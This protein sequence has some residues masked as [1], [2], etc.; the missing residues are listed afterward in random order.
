MNKTIKKT[1]VLIVSLLSLSV[2]LFACSTSTSN[3]NNP[4]GS[5][6]DSSDEGSNT[7]EGLPV[8]ISSNGNSY[9]INDLTVTENGSGNTVVTCSASG[10]DVVPVVGG[11]TVIPIYCSIIENGV[12]TEFVSIQPGIDSVD[13]IFNTKLDPDTV[14][15]YPQDNRGKR[16]EITIK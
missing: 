12:E 7:Y 16:T 14:V 15:F 4:D 11:S 5:Q 6:S 9:T 3:G 8:T 2:V 10:F 13:F 1:I